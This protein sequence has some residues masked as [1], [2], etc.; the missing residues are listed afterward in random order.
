MKVII[1]QA[2]PSDAEQII[3]YMQRLSEEPI[4]NIVISPGEFTHTI[5]EEERVL[6][7]FASSKTSIFLV[8][9]AE[10]NI[11]GIL[12]CRGR[13]D[14]KAIHHVVSLGMSVDQDWRGQ[15]IGSQLIENTIDWAKGTGFIKR[16]TLLVF[17]RNEV[18][19]R[20]YQKFGFEIEGKHHKA[21]YRDGIYLD[22]LTMALLL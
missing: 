21:I 18:A 19:I 22:N 5:A 16:I 12:N 20:L 4:S 6:S 13:S 14:R 10:R 1:R 2:Q 17:E 11:V 9:E 15:G 8:A 3:K 7:E